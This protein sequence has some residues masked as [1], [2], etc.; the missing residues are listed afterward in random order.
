VSPAKPP[1]GLLGR[2]YA[3]AFV[4]GAFGLPTAACLWV[5]YASEG[6]MAL[7]A[8]V[9]VYLLANMAAIFVYLTLTVAPEPLDG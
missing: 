6:L 3:S 1:Y 2:L 4:L 7:V 8:T 9:M 5:R